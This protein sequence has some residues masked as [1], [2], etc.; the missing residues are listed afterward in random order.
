MTEAALTSEI[1]TQTYV[2][3]NSC[4]V[5]CI[6]W[7]GRL[8]NQAVFTINNLRTGQVTEQMCSMGLWHMDDEYI[9]AELGLE[10]KVKLTAVRYGSGAMFL[11]DAGGL[12]WY[13]VRVRA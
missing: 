6:F 11:Q 12:V 3:L 4:Q 5:H 7:E 13:D 10:C 1:S 2:Q 8:S 9:P